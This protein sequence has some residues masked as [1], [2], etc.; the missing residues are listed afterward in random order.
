[1]SYLACVHESDLIWGIVSLRSWDRE[2]KLEHAS[3]GG[4]DGRMRFRRVTDISAF[5][6]LR[7]SI[8]S[9]PVVGD[10]EDMGR[11]GKGEGDGKSPI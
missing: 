2:E 5:T 8:R 4:Y 9:R 11:R 10:G 1:M 7:T 6:G 3:L